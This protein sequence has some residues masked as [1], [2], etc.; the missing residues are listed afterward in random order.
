MGKNRISPISI[1]LAVVDL[2]IISLSYRLSF[3][4]KFGHDV[5]YTN[6]NAYTHVMPFLYIATV[7]TFYLFNLYTAAVNRSLLKV[8]Y[9]LFLAMVIIT[10]FTMG[11]AYLSQSSALP[12]SVALLTP[13]LEFALFAIS[14]TIARLLSQRVYKPKKLL[15][16]EKTSNIETRVLMRKFTNQNDKVFATYEIINEHE[17][18]SK[19]DEVDVVVINSGIE[20]KKKVI[21]LCVKKGKEVLLV[22]DL[23]EILINSAETQHVDDTLMLV[24]KPPGL[25]V[26]QRFAKRVFDLIIALLI[27][28]VASPIMIFL[29]FLISILSPGPA[30]FS[31]ERLGE[32]GLPFKVMKFRSMINNAE[33]TTG[34]VLAVE[35]DPRIT[36]FG[37]FLRA[38][39]LD[40]LPQLIN[41]IKGEMSIVGPRPEREFFVNQFTE[42]IPHYRFRMEVKPGITGLAQVMGKYT[43]TPEDKLRFDLMYIRNY[44]FL[45]DIRTLLQT[46]KVVFQREK[47]AGVEV[48][49]KVDIKNLVS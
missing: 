30:I 9:S 33:Q 48:R 7:L 36:R 18:Q 24:I 21:N 29:M 37:A 19:I 11:Y 12:R 10:V 1:F 4:I 26:G 17:L 3:L 22:P 39:R 28:L 27:L 46:V 43:T 25:D 49:T 15:L 14:R 40:E 8:L 38:T 35:K 41:V 45:L 42:T 20:D 34:P 47:A 16:V 23:L 31:Q 2:G 44:S 32:K 5:P 6:W 13:L